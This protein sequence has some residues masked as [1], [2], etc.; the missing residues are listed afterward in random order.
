MC[1]AATSKHVCTITLT[2][3]PRDD[4]ADKIL[5][6]SHFQLFMKRLRRQ[7]HK[8]RYLVAGEYGDLKGRAH[9]H[10]ILFFSAIS[11]CMAQAPWYN[12]AHINDPEN[13]NPFNLQIPQKRISHIREWPHGHIIADWSA[14]EKSAK[15]VCKYL[16]ADEKH[17]AWFSLSKKPTIG[18]EW[19]MQKAAKARELGVLPSA[20]EYMPPGGTKGKSYLMTG[21]TRRDYLNAIT[22]TELSDNSYSAFP[23]GNGDRRH[24]MSEWVAK[25]FDK[26]ERQRFIDYL[27]S[28][29]VDLESEAEEYRERMQEADEVRKREFRR[30]LAKK[31]DELTEAI[32]KSGN[33]YIYYVNGYT[34]HEG[35]NY[36]PQPRL[37]SQFD[38]D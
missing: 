8:V 12:P 27:E 30:Y 4:F 29:P 19:F 13:S 14:S 32:A 3:A 37:R 34:Y 10:A 24:R 1:E 7:G 25:T 35:I 17:N 5:H 36:G 18:H 28:L 33:P 38:R 6:P 31:W 16:L 11:D 2:Y 20:F 22:G 15:Y 26:H 23:Y 21:A 9:F